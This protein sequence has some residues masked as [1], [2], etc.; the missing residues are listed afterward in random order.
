MSLFITVLLVGGVSGVT[1]A[2]QPTLSV[3]PTGGNKTQGASFQ[4]SV[5]L[6]GAGGKICAVE[7]TVVFDNLSCRSITAV[8]DDVMVQSSPTC[9]RPHFLVGIPN[10]TTSGKLLFNVVVNAPTIGS[11]A[12]RLNDV[13]VVGEGVSLSPEVTGASYTIV[14]APQGSVPAT[15]TEEQEIPFEVQ[16]EQPT[17]SPAATVINEEPNLLLASIGSLIT[18]KTGNNIVGIIVLFVI[19]FVVYLLITYF[20]RKKSKK[21]NGSRINQNTRW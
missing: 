1:Y 17:S 18:L 7:G 21:E 3:S 20:L 10:C 6:N 13:D 15:T 8:A 9:A 2:V 11:A 19:C 4:S 16:V 14:A 12:I 5:N